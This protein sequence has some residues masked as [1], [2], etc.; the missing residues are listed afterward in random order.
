MNRPISRELQDSG[1][2]KGVQVRLRRLP[3]V[4]DRPPGRHQRGNGDVYAHLT[5]ASLTPQQ[6][7]S[8]VQLATSPGYY[9]D[10]GMTHYYMIPSQ[11][12]PLLEPLNQLPQAV[13]MLKPI[14]Q[15]FIDLTQPDL[16]YLVDLGYDASVCLND[17]RQC[18]HPIRAVP[19]RQP[20]QLSGGLR[21][22][23]SDRNQRCAG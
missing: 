8:A 13:P 14:I 3:E 22:E 18:C 5:Y 21:P 1:L 19:E 7:A 6:L 16:K 10:G 2:P 11:T 9:A 4:P 12:L 15:P 23:H 17:I 20:H